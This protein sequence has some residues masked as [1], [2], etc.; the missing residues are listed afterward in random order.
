M[1]NP[2]TD[3]NFEPVYSEPQ[4]DSRP[5][6]AVLE[7]GSPTLVELQAKP[8]NRRSV[9]TKV[10]HLITG[11]MPEVPVTYA[12][13][14][15]D[16]SMTVLDDKPRVPDPVPDEVGLPE[17]Y[18]GKLPPAGWCT[19][20]P[21]YVEPELREAYLAEL[22]DA[23]AEQERRDKMFQSD[24]AMFSTPGEVTEHDVM[25]ERKPPVQIRHLTLSDPFLREL[26]LHVARYNVAYDVAIE[27]PKRAE[28]KERM[29]F[30]VL[31]THTCGVCGVSDVSQ[32]MPHH[33][34]VLGGTEPVCPP[35]SAVADRLAVELQAS[36]QVDTPQGPMR[37]EDA[38]AA[39][40]GLHLTKEH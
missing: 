17:G 3:L 9:M 12:R 11:E 37:R 15:R 19:P 34:M 38:V 26:W 16:G 20:G 36:A 2:P 8:E 23:A 35:C 6:P 21:T 14:N 13:M 30:Y 39:V 4:A 24:G 31:A 40:F 25:V 7:Q 29:E 1:S 33:P 27:Q 32:A 18:A 28:I 22:N 5:V 10:K